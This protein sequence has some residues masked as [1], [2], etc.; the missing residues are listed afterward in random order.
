MKFAALVLAYKEPEMVNKLLEQLLHEFGEDIRVFIHV[1]RG[2]EY[3][4]ETLLSHPQIE[5]LPK[6]LGIDPKELEGN[7]KN[8]KLWADDGLIKRIMYMFNYVQNKYNADYYIVLS[9]QDLIVKKGI[10]QFLSDN[11]MKIFMDGGKDNANQGA[12]LLY[13][14]PIVFFKNYHNK[15]HPLR[16]LRRVLLL[17]YS[18]GIKI[19]RQK[20]ANLFDHVDLFKNFYW[21]SLPAECVKYVIDYANNNPEVMEVYMNSICPEESFFSTTL[22]NQEQFHDMFNWVQGTKNYKGITYFKT[23]DTAFP[24]IEESDI[25]LIENSEVF[26]AKKF[27][28]S[29]NEKL[30][31]YFYKKIMEDER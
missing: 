12:R 14:W 7:K 2:S 24:M 31:D 6:H 20:N 16:I 30:V 10:K 21:M 27:S 11:R 22:A 26:F 1:S 25:E 3:M 28:V 19:N 4:I 23:F 13:K 8:I 5:I 18:T 29:Y 9:G 17:I 15:F